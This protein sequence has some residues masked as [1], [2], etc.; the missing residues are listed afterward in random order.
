[1]EPIDRFHWENQRVLRRVRTQAVR[2]TRHSPL[3]AV[4]G[5]SAGLDVTHE[6]TRESGLTRCAA[7]KN[8]SAEKNRQQAASDPLRSTQPPAKQHAGQK[9]LA[10]PKNKKPAP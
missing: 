4:I 6:K 5:G 2:I 10:A 9:E 3:L 7:V 8:R 1:M